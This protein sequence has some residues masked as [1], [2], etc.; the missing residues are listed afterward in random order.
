MI[1]Y[2]DDLLKEFLEHFAGFLKFLFEKNIFQA[3]IAFVLA[4]QINKLFLD[5]L[6]NIVT[7]VADRVIS[8]E[9]K[10]Q[11]TEVFGVKFLT[12]NFMLSVI[13]FM[14]VMIVLYHLYKISDSSK[15]LFENIA[16]KLKF[17]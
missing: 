8:S 5:F 16:S 7:P 6:S 3:G 11:T 12:G 1:Q 2:L 15:T 13:N 9:I 4:S 17:W 14:I 10:T